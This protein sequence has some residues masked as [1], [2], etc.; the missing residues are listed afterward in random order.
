[1][2][3]WFTSDTHFNHARIIE[4]SNRPFKANKKQSA[5][6][7]MNEELIRRW[8]EV[9][10]PEDKVYHL[11]DFGLGQMEDTLNIISRLNGT[12]TLVTGNHDRNFRGGRRS[13]G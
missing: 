5:I 12:K 7:V 6:E 13:A 9:V 8:N 10:A 11:K 4:L 1:M 2:T 3:I